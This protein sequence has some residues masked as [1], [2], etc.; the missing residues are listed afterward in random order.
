MWTPKPPVTGRLVPGLC[1]GPGQLWAAFHCA[2]A[3]QERRRGP[4]FFQRIQKPP[5]PDTAAIGEYLFLTLI[6]LPF[7]DDAQYLSDPLRGDVT[8][9]HLHLGT[10]FE[11][12]RNRDCNT[13]AVRPDD[14]WRRASISNEVSF[15]HR[16]IAPSL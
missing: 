11:V 6:A 8:I 2:A 3:H 4:G 12:D 14:L 16:T 10:F 5:E 9:A 1:D 15:R 13:R 7:R